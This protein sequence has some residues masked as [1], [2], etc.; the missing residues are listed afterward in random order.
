[1][2]T[3]ID[4]LSFKNYTNPVSDNRKKQKQSGLRSAQRRR[5]HDCQHRGHHHWPQSSSN[6][7]RHRECKENLVCEGHLS[8]LPDVLSADDG[9]YGSPIRMPHGEEQ[10]DSFVAGDPWCRCKSKESG[11]W[12]QPR[13]KEEDAQEVDLRNR[14]ETCFYH[15]E[16]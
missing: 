15:F 16:V 4:N 5:L 8:M 12:K 11:L 9:K 7:E 1:M 2:F 10:E 3:G 14:L 13:G 6:L